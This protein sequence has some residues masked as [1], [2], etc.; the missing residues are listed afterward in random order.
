V[1][2]GF[3][4]GRSWA[5]FKWAGY[6][7]LQLSASSSLGGQSFWLSV[8][9]VTREALAWWFNIARA[10]VWTVLTLLGVIAQDDLR[11]LI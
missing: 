10:G 7:E 9:A 8:R 6:G 11:L 1:T 4:L 2:D 5:T 3:H